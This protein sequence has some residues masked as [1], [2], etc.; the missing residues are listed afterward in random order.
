MDTLTVVVASASGLALGYATA[1]HFA[2][3]ARSALQAKLK[4]E[5]SAL[6]DAQ[7]KLKALKS[8]GDSKKTGKGKTKKDNNN[9]DSKKLEKLEKQLA[10]GTKEIERLKNANM[11]SEKSH[12]DAVAKLE[13]RVEAVKAEAAEAAEAAAAA[14]ESPESRSADT[15]APVN[16]ELQASLDSA[17]ASLDEILNALVKHEGQT[18]VL[19]GD[20]NGIIIAKAGDAETVENTAAASNTLITLPQK[21]NGMLPLNKHFGFRLQDG[22]SAITGRAFETDGEQMALTTVGALAPAEASLLAVVKQISSALR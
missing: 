8:G 12:S 19:L 6:K 18:G 11:A 5:S 16:A 1:A 21:L 9:K 2:S 14:A 13:A 17:G 20:S 4:D 22:D 10:D 7:S 15:S 3:E